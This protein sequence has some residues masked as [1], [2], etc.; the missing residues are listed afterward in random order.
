MLVRDADGEHLAI[1]RIRLT[2]LG[3]ADAGAVFEASGERVTLGTHERC[4]LI[5]REQTVSRWHAEL[6]VEDGHVIVTDLG[7]SNGT[8]INGVR[9]ERAFLTR[10]GT[11][12]L[13]RAIFRFDVADQPVKLPLS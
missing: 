4:D 6:H 9:V 10:G 5:L 1:Q 11:L 7:S 13:G 3:G 8:T 12:G 2:A